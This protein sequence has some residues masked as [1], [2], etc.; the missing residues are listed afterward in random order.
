MAVLPENVR[1]GD[2][3][4]VVGEYVAINE[5]DATH[6]YRVVAVEPF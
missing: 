6:A 3:A 4:F 1:F 2:G 5:D